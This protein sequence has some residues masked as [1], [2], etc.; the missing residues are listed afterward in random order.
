MRR[1]CLLNLVIEGKIEVQEDEE[2][3]V[4]NYLLTLS[5]GGILLTERGRTRSHCV[6]KSV[7]KGL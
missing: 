4:R 3:D 1:N 2:E 6:E 5:K 7:W